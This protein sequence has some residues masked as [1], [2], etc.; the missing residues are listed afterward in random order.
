MS[1]TLYDASVA[2][3]KDALSALAAVLT[4]AESHAATSA[5][6][7]PAARLYDDMLP[8]SFQVFMTTDVAQKLAARGLGVDPLD[9]SRDL[10]TFAA[11]QAR[12]AQV[13]EVLAKVDREAF[14]ARVD[15]EVTVGM[16]AGKEAK[17]K[18]KEYVNGYAIPN[19]F[20]HTTTAYGILRKEGV[21]LGKMDYLTPFIGKYVSQ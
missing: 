13:Q 2:T 21:P 20:F 4:K 17:M 8:L 10:E 14:D 7:L 5:A 15:A 19:L 12:I 16:G 3:A 9:L 11:M 1:Y 18:L 6:A